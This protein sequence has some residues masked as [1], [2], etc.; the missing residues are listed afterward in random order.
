MNRGNRHRESAV[1][2]MK[3]P[4]LSLPLA[5][6]ALLRSVLA[7]DEFSQEPRTLKRNHDLYDYYALEH[8]TRT[9]VPLDDI[10]QS[11]GLE[12]VEPVGQL[13]DH[14]LLR[15]PKYKE[16]FLEKRGHDL[17]Q[18]L[19]R[20]R[21]SERRDEGVERIATAVKQLS[22]QTL[23]KRVKRTVDLKR[24]PQPID[25]LSLNS[26]DVAAREGIE[27]PIFGDQWHLVNDENPMHMVNAA[28]VWDMGIHGEGVISAMVDDGLDYE[29]DDLADNF[30]SCYLY[31]AGRCRLQW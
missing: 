17:L 26:S 1:P 28:P 19:A 25:W 30:V 2:I 23:R 18:S 21:T 4:Q 20:R 10:L 8:D 14:W 29:S 16:G 22:L 15:V 7:E 3:V 13:K 5:L 11:L 27:D 31:M 9:N 6:V 24:A 12:L